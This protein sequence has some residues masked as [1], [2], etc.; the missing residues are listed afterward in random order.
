MKAQKFGITI[1]FS[2][3]FT[4]I[5]FTLSLLN[6]PPKTDAS[7]LT[8]E[9]T[10]LQYVVF[11]SQLLYGNMFYDVLKRLQTFPAGDQF[12][13]TAKRVLFS[14]FVLAVIVWGAVMVARPAPFLSYAAIVVAIS[15][16]IVMFTWQ[17]PKLQPA[18]RSAVQ[19]TNG[20]KRDPEVDSGTRAKR[21]RGR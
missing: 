13:D 5:I 21:R 17:L 18:Y 16:Y 2:V 19:R 3:V 6:S 11:T 10:F 4:A 15:A 7:P 20:P 8:L 9:D 1:C 12:W 14:L